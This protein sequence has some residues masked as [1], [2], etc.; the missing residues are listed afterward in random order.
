MSDSQVQ[1]TAEDT[2]I[3]KP[4]PAHRPLHPPV[5][6]PETFFQG[7][8]EASPAPAPLWI[9]EAR[10]HAAFEALAPEWDALAARTGDLVLYS[11]AFLR[12]W[13][14]HFAPHA[15]L[16]VLT[17]RD[18]QGRLVAALALMEVKARQYGVPVRQLVS[19]SNKHSGRFDMLAE[20]PSV[21][22]TAFAAHLARDPSWDVL[23]LGDVPEDGAAHAL[24]AAFAHAG[25][26]VGVWHS[27]RSPYVLLPSTP[28]A[29][30]GPRK[31]DHK[32]L[33]RRRRR[34]EERGHVTIER[35]G[36]GEALGATLAECF[37]LELR[38]WKGRHG[39][40]IAQDPRTLGFYSDLART[41]ARSG[42][43]AL[44][45][46]RL[47]GR[48]IAFQLGLAHAGRYLALKP[49]YD[50]ALH[51]LS[52]GQLLTESLLQD[53]IARGL[54]ECDLL[55]DDTPSKRVWT[56]TTRPHGWLYVFR[57]T[58]AGRALWSAKFRWAPA[59]KR[60]VKRWV[61]RH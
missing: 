7:P 18:A 55:G 26:P 51:E 6:P 19:L 8:A 57:D 35:I 29:W 46:L 17:G 12:C 25:L 11:H 52:P 22:G 15:S 10:S 1:H 61:R 4:H 16:R 14:T 50:E 53:C 33:R 44:Y 54:S 36:Q 56:D 49:G 23:R 24:L 41:A 30:Q 58:L 34:L 28:G 3:Q 31:R 39:T 43:L 60:V 45:V 42:Q 59:A 20:V 38:G 47:D 21:A 5:P 48:I 9:Q 40:A 32:A 13:L 2:P 37:A 27:A